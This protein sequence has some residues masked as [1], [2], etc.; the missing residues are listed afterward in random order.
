[1]THGLF[2]KRPASSLALGQEIW[3]DG[4]VK[5]TYLESID[6]DL[7]RVRAIRE[8]SGVVKDFTCDL[9][10]LIPVLRT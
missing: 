5:I 8:Y 6:Y 1:M 7:V 2:E 4:L 10:E 9:S 3:W